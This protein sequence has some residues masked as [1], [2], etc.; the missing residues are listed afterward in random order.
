L[1]ALPRGT[2][3]VLAAIVL[4]AG[5]SPD[6]E[7]LLASI[8]SRIMYG[9]PDT[10]PAHNAVVALYDG[11]SLCSGT[12]IAPKVVLTA[13]HCTY[14]KDYGSIYVLFGANI[15]NAQSRSVSEGWRHPGYSHVVPPPNDI[16]LLRL[17]QDAPGGVAPIPHLPASLG[18]TQ[19]DVHAAVEFSGFGQTE[20]GQIG[21]KLHVSNNLELVCS[22]G[23]GCN[24]YGTVPQFSICYDENPGGPCSGDSGG[25]AFITRGGQEY[26]AGVTSWGDQNC[27]QLG[28]STQVDAFESDLIE[29]IGGVQGSACTAD[30]QCL[31]GLLCVDNICC[32]ARCATCQACNVPGHLGSCFAAAD[33]TPCPDSDQCNGQETCVQGACAPGTVQLCNNGGMCRTG[34][35][36]PATGC[37]YTPVAEGTTCSNGDVC[38][39]LETCQ[40]GVCQAGE[41]LMCDDHNPCTVDSCDS[42]NGCLHQALADGA[43]CGG[44]VCGAAACAGGV[45]VYQQADMCDDRNACTVDTCDPQSGCEN[46]QLADGDSCG[47]CKACQANQCVDVPE[48]DQVVEGSCGCRASSPPPALAALILLVAFMIRRRT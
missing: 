35:C 23:G 25:P 33:G 44:G 34:S 8:G 27:V 32:S 3:A 30:A 40:A 17:S 29:F 12:L 5:C 43:D 2:F 7:V 47:E 22:T 48:C 28:C 41:P 9:S 31:P 15:Q 4:L 45:C 18:L 10:N 46:F 14:G 16:S 21:T 6:E 13:G 19:A 42:W 1:A 38:D 39:G 11:A 37:Q 26:V 24:Y 20:Y 36:D